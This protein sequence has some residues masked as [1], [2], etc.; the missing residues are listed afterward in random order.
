MAL[1]PCDSPA[2]VLNDGRCPGEGPRMQQVRRLWWQLVPW[3][4]AVSG[5]LTVLPFVAALATPLWALQWRLARARQHSVK[6]VATPLL[7]VV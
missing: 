5:T 1:A 3:V 7:G 6:D 4:L 2:L